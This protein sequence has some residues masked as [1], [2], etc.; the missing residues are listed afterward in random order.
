MAL[1]PLTADITLTATNQTIFTAGA[2]C[3]VTKAIAFNTDSTARTITI[4]KVPNSGTAGTGNEIAVMS[5]PVNPNPPTVLRFSGLVLGP[6]DTI[7]GFAS[8]TGVVNIS[9]GVAQP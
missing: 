8:L 3:F 2:A 6:S 5:I 1:L 9:I 7:Q 4:Y